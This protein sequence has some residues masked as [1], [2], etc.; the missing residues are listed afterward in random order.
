M[1]VPPKDG[2]MIMEGRKRKRIHRCSCRECKSRRSPEVAE[3]HRSINCVM[4][5]LDERHRR[6]FAGLLA[7]QLGR[8]GRQRVF[9]IT[10]L[11]RVTI[12]RGLRECDE[13]QS[14]ELDRVRRA[15]GGRKLLEKK[16]PTSK[17]N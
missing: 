7:R 6:L 16:G 11:S 13:A 10:G 1:I 14:A 3:Y 8:G 9:E 12:G 4:L 5:E 2:E 15:G 17:L